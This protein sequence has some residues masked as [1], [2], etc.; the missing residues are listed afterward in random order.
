MN[1]SKKPTG[2]SRR[3]FEEQFWE[4]VVKAGKDECMAASPLD[5]A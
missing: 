1:L 4:K 5:E 3:P 2:R